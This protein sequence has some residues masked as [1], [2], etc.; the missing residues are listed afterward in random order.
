MTYMEPPLPSIVEDV[1]AMGCAALLL[2][3]GAAGLLFAVRGLI[4]VA[5]ALAEWIGHIGG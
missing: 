4:W 2:A 3:A 1:A 5:W